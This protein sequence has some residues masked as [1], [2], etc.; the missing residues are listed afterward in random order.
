MK[1]VLLC[2]L[3]A[4]AFAGCNKP[5]AEESDPTPDPARKTA[6]SKPTV[7]P[8]SG[9][10]MWKNAKGTPRSSDPFSIPDDPLAHKSKK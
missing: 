1:K 2:L 5:E 8:K 7:T 10:W 4:L 6:A 9:D 3:A